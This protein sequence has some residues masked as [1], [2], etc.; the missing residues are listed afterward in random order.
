V[1]TF[2]RDITAGVYANIGSL[3][4]VRFWEAPTV[5]LPQP[6]FSIPIV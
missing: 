6:W 3:K 2:I 5:N 4:Y 1:K